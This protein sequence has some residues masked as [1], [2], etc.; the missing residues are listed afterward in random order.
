MSKKRNIKVETLLWEG[1]SIEVSYEPFYLGMDFI[2]HLQL[3]AV[4]PEAVPL[5]MTE[6]GYR[7]HFI[8]RSYIEAEGG[9]LAYALAW[10]EAEAAKPEWRARN[11]KA[12]QLNLF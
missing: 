4:S 1:I 5:P 11:E 3:H 9:P 6:T 10:L 2:A 12:R 7:S 8:D